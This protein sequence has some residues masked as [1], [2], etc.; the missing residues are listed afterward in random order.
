MHNTKSARNFWVYVA[1]KGAISATGNS[2][3]QHCRVFSEQL[4]PERTVEA[5]LLWHKVTVEDP[6]C[7][8]RGEVLNF[9][10]ANDDTV[11]LMMIQLTNITDQNMQITPTAAIPIFARSAE[12]IRDHRHVTSL[13]NRAHVLPSGLVVKPEIV[14]DEKGHRYNKQCYYVLGCQG[15]GTLPAG[16]FPVVH[17]F[18]GSAG[19]LEWPQSI[20]ENHSPATVADQENAVL[21]GVEYI[22]ALRFVDVELE[23]GEKCSYVLMIGTDTTMDQPGEVFSRY[24]SWDKA[25]QIFLDTC[26]HWQQLSERITF[27]GFPGHFAEWMRWVGVQPVFRKIYG[28][29]FMPYHDYGK[30]GRGW[31]DLWQDCLSLILF[32]PSE[33]RQMLMDNFGGVR[34]DGTNATII[35]NQRG[36]FIADRNNIARVWMDH[37]AW[38]YMTTK[39]YID[40]T[41]DVGILLSEQ[42]Y[43]HD[44][45]IMRASER[46]PAY[47][48]ANGTGQFSGTV[49]EHILV[50]HLT[51]FFHVGEHNIILLEGADW[52]D[53][54]D[55]ARERGESTAFTALYGS[56]LISMAE[57]LE[58]G[59]AMLGITQ[60]SLFDE[61]LPLLDTLSAN[62]DY[63]NILEKKAHLQMYMSSVSSGIAGRKTSVAIVDLVKDLR[64]KG[65]WI[66]THLRRQ[67]WIATHSGDGFFNGYYNN[68]GERVDGSY[69]DGLRMN[70]TAQVF[71]TMF[72]LADEGQR[73]QAYR[74]T[75]KYLRDPQTGGTRLNTPLGKHQLNFGPMFFICLW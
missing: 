52:N 48:A 19:S 2:A 15:D 22:G 55:M 43:F 73:Q 38:P 64:K 8:V 74:A 62:V 39:L 21:P 14:F 37:G 49:L 61:L 71:T 6:D 32:S 35:G 9:V 75:R 5:G 67:E 46:D 36:E 41:G 45:L 63:D 23:P 53:T 51:S 4:R 56:N 18:I 28:N 16:F 31:R 54:L 33:V 69:A 13:V 72:G 57:L 66:F 40:Q 11:E 58:K 17:D 3:R 29:S 20:V 70:L 42:S 65:E 44:G 47:Q 50:Q 7:G 12:N 59:A 34:L 60:V 25:H 26:Q 27:D 10:P 1:G 68:D 30:G 24:N